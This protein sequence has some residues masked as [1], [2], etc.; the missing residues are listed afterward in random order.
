M[1]ACETVLPQNFGKETKCTHTQP[2]Y[3]QQSNSELLAIQRSKPT[4]WAF[5][6]VKICKGGLRKALLTARTKA[7][8]WAIISLKHY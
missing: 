3:I 7:I 5:Y 4:A 8:Q 6:N 1:D 2:S